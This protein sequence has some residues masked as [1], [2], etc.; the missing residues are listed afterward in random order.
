MYNCTMDIV[1]DASAI[2]AVLLN[3]PERD[4]IITSSKGTRLLAP[5]SLPCEIGN[6]VSALIKRKTLTIAQG[7]SVYHGFS[8]IPIRFVPI[9]FPEAIRIA[10]EDNLYAYDAYVLQV[11]QSFQ[12]PLM[13]LDRRLA[14]AATRRA[15]DL[16]EI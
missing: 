6:A 16:R 3:E 15:L 13:T 12:A 11:A 14:A 10:G 8:G 2:L 4:S 7:V 9:D 1:L 5:E